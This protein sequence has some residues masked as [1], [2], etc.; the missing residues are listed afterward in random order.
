MEG[1]GGG[2]VNNFLQ[3]IF[4]ISRISLQTF[5]QGLAVIYLKNEIKMS[6]THG[7]VSCSL[8][9]ILESWNSWH[10]EPWI[11]KFMASSSVRNPGS[12]YEIL[13]RYLNPGMNI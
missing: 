13:D 3:Q 5:I 2:G 4:L 6:T 9:L 8:R 1:C 12:I 11:Y 10:F 7:K